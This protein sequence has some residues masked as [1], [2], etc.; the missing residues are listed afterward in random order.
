[1]VVVVILRL[2][3]HWRQLSDLK[4]NHTFQGNLRRFSNKCQ[5]VNIWKNIF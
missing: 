1:M 5:H 3:I 4:K 2:T